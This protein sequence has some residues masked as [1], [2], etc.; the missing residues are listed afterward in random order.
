LLGQ[1][2][3]DGDQ[4]ASGA[5]DF[6]AD[7]GNAFNR[8]PAVKIPG[9]IL[10]DPAVGLP[11]LVNWLSDAGCTRIRYELRQVNRSAESDEE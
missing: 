6:G 1:V 4:P 7:I 11:A 5:D 2:K 10:H 3:F 9:I 8:G